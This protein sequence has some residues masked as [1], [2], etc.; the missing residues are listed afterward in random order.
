MLRE[1]SKT[2]SSTVLCPVSSE[3]EPEAVF[4][5]R[6]VSKVYRMGEVEVT[7]GLE[8]GAEV[9]VHLA[10]QVSDGAPVEPQRNSAS[11]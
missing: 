5:A 3:G 2:E 6:G 10:N 11:P 7:R 9:V 1:V 4:I 8:E